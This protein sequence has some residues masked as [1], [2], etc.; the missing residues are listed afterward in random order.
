[1]ERGFARVL[2]LILGIAAI[3]TGGYLYFQS[4]NNTQ[5][6]VAPPQIVDETAAWKI[7]SAHGLYFKYPRNWGEPDTAESD[8]SLFKKGLWAARIYNDKKDMSLDITSGWNEGDPQEEIDKFIEDSCTPELLGKKIEISGN[9]SCLTGPVDLPKMPKSISIQFFNNSNN[10]M[11]IIVLTA[12]Q[13]YPSDDL[14]KMAETIA[15]TVKII[16][17]IKNL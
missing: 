7:F 16:P 9:V 14:T 3:S 1:M 10:S 6:Q 11:N 13:D 15:K 2:L 5:K 17:Y 12:T 8:G 4:S